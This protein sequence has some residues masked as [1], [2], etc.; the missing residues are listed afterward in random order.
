MI[1]QD[2]GLLKFIKEY[3]ILECSKFIK[4]GT[5]YLLYKKTGGKKLLYSEKIFDEDGVCKIANSHRAVVL[6]DMHPLTVLGFK[7]YSNTLKTFLVEFCCARIKSIELSTANFGHNNIKQNMIESKYFFRITGYTNNVAVPRTGE[8]VSTV[9]LRN[10]SDG[11][12]YSFDYRDIEVI[13]P[14][15]E[16]LFKG[17]NMPLDRTIRVG[18][19][20]KVTKKVSSDLSVGSRGIVANKV[21][22]GSKMYCDVNINDKLHRIDSSKLRIVF[23]PNEVVSKEE[24]SKKDRLEKKFGKR[25]AR[26]SSIRS[27]EPTATDNPWG[28]TIASEADF[29]ETFNRLWRQTVISTTS[30]DTPPIPQPTQDSPGPLGF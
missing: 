4:E 16:D 7:P 28:F 11:R 14:N 20:V 30:T 24:D 10:P 1:D 18:R 19:L 13:V 17:Y 2:E 5:S 22:A 6:D 9:S 12:S 15:P 25:T 23:N 8:M 26:G 29:E 21:N 3:N 27:E